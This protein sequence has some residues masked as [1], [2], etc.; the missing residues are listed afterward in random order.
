MD[1]VN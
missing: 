1:Q